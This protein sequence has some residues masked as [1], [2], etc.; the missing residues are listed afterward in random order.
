MFRSFAATS[1]MGDWLILV[2][3]V[4]IQGG[5]DPV[6][7]TGYRW[8]RDQVSRYVDCGIP[9]TGSNACKSTFFSSAQSV[10]LS[11]QAGAPRGK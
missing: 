10:V 2:T 11:P 8:S 3:D 5:Q 4:N 1:S 9:A 7:P 6:P